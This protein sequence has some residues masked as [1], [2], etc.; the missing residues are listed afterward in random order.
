MKAKSGKFVS[1]VSGTRCQFTEE[2]KEEA[3]RMLLDGHTAISVCERL[4]LSSPNLLY[5]WHRIFVGQPP[6][7]VPPAT[8]GPD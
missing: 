1:E 8:L 4:G 3:V 6:P 7:L 2:F 5:R